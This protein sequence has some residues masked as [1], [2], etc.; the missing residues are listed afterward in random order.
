MNLLVG[1]FSLAA[2]VWLV[3]VIRRGGV[4]PIGIVVL[5]VG[6]VLG[7]AFLLPV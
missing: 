7:P 6:T 4:I 3:P 5:L 2:L 1:M